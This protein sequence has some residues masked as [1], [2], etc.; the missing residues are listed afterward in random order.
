MIK[1]VIVAAFL[2]LG[3]AIRPSIAVRPTVRAHSRD[4]SLNPVCMKLDPEPSG[5]YEVSQKAAERAETMEYFKTLGGFSAASLGLYVALTVGAGLDDVL[6]G[7]LVLIALVAFGTYLLFFDGGVTQAAL[8]QQAIQQL[9]E[10]EGDIM[11]SAP[12]ARIGVFDAQATNTNPDALSEALEGQGCARLNRLISASSAKELLEFINGALEE[13][14]Q[15]VASGAAVEST[16]FGDV[17]MRE[18]SELRCMFQ[19]AWLS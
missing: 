14:R 4:G 9:A 19:L 11:S 15:A 2:Q 6:A 10:E 7:N 16:N 12:R 8:E 1:L 5:I 17:L 13:K 18:N 3:T